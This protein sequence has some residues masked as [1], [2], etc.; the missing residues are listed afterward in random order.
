MSISVVENGRTLIEEGLG[1]ADLETGQ[2]VTKDTQF[3]IA[4][5]TKAFTTTLLSKLISMSR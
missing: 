4:S 5:L 3:C 2:T 1:L